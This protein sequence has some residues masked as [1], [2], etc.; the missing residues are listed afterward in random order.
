[1]EEKTY[2]ITFKR[3]ICK[4]EIRASVL[5][6]AKE[7]LSRYN[8]HKAAKYPHIY[9]AKPS[10]ALFK[11]ALSD[12]FISVS[13]HTS[14]D[15]AIRFSIAPEEQI[16]S[17]G[18]LSNIR[19]LIIHKTFKYLDRTDREWL[20]NWYHNGRIIIRDPKHIDYGPISTRV[21]YRFIQQRIMF[22]EHIIFGKVKDLSSVVKML[23]AYGEYNATLDESSRSYVDPEICEKAA[24]C[25]ERLLN[26]N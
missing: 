12:G 22:D 25:C 13:I 7:N 4:C 11:D 24:R 16:E 6:V 15:T 3:N 23:R 5:R 20:E 14:S 21:A 19:D 2:L 1:M 10:A 8:L 17:V 26:K 18:P 9:Y